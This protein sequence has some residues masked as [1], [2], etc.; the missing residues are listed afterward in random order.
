MTFIASTIKARRSSWTIGI[1]GRA[2]N[3][4][5]WRRCEG[6]IAL[7]VV[8][9]GFISWAQPEESFDDDLTLAAVGKTRPGFATDFALAKDGEMMI[10]AYIGAPYTYPSDVHVRTPGKHDFTAKDVEWV[11]EPF[12]NPIYYGV[13]VLR[14]GKSARSGWMVDFT[15]SK[16]VADE[17]QTLDLDGLLDGEPAPQGK[18]IREVFDK[19]E[20][21]HGHNMLTFNGLMRLPALG[22]RVFPYVGLGAGVQQDPP[23]FASANRRSPPNADGVGLSS[24]MV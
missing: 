15:H 5:G 17:N 9:A 4:E 12:D 8:A 23:L 16:A 3:K 20:A 11:G 22:A 6:V 1:A 14:W 19:L 18:N 21:S 2:R 7:A 24:V 13:R 10:A